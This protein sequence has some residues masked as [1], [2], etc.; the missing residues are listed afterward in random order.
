VNPGLSFRGRL[1]TSQRSWA[2]RNQAF[3]VLLNGF[4]DG[5]KSSHSAGAG[6]A[7]I[8]P[9]S[10]TENNLASPCIRAESGKQNMK[11]NFALDNTSS[12][13]VVLSPRRKIRR[14]K[15]ADKPY[16]VEWKGVIIWCETPGEA[17]DVARQLGGAPDHPHYQVW[18]VDEFTDFVSRI[19]VTQRRLLNVLLKANCQPVKDHVLCKAVGVATNQGLAGA[20]SGITKVAKAMDIEPSRIYY[21]RTEYNQGSPVR[22]YYITPAFM[23][24]ATDADWPSQHDLKEPNED[25]ERG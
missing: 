20:L 12:V 24:A 3:C 7:P 8:P 25:D 5:G 2:A 1:V 10:D 4:D 9:T 23:R 22:K 17:A 15:M 14:K 19:Q 11:R 6:E 13:S 16:K 18:R 21:Q